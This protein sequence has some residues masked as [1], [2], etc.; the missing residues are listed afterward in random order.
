VNERKFN[1]IN[2]YREFI[3]RI[4]SKPMC[5]T[6]RMNGSKPTELLKIAE[7]CKKHIRRDG[8]K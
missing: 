8:R 7:Q 3:N 6:P 1:L 2:A 4:S 5:E